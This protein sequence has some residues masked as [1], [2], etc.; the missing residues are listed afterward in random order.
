M[1][2]VASPA[3]K[4]PTPTVMERIAATAQIWVAGAAVILVVLMIVPVAPWVLDV[5]L[6][7]NIALAL[8]I[9]LTSLYTENALAF[10]VFPTLIL[11]VTLFRLSLNISATRSILLHGYAGEV[12]N[13][14]GAIVVGGNYAVGLVIFAILVVIQFVVIT[15]GAG[16][17]AEVADGFTLDAMHGKQLADDADLTAG[18]ITEADARQRRKDIPRSADFY[19][20]MDGASKFVRGD[21]VAALIIVAINTI[22]G[23]IVGVAQLHLPIDVALQR[24]TLLTVGEGIV[25]QVPALL[26]STA[27]GIIVTRAAAE[28][29]F[30]EELTS[31]LVQEPPAL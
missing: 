21:A 7:L 16:R 1:A 9:I 24:F 11:I 29:S 19:V 26:I 15:N 5:L 28:Q 14:F 22:G 17:V 4:P 30:G 13:Q 3:P 23:F 12:I 2:A 27:T 6:S 10:S 18:L 25:T 31:Q 8:V 20:A